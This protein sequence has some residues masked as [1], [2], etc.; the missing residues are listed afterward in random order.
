MKIG[1]LVYDQL[2]FTSDSIVRL[3]KIVCIHDNDSKVNCDV[4]W[5]GND[6]ALEKNIPIST[7]RNLDLLKKFQ[8]DNP[9]DKTRDC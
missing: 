4:Y 1:E 6:G 2:A 9:Q 3:G 8:R 7:V 5:F